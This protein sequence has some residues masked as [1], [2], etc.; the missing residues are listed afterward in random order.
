[1][2]AMKALW[3]RVVVEKVQLVAGWASIVLLIFAWL[4]WVFSMPSV[5]LA[6]SIG[7]AY[8]DF[9]MGIALMGYYI[10]MGILAA[11]SIIPFGGIAVW[12][13]TIFLFND[14]ALSCFGL[15]MTDWPVAVFF[16]IPMA[17]GMVGQ[18]IMDVL[19]VKG[20]LGFRSAFTQTPGLGF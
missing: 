14:A 1:M 15:S 20:I 19:L 9:L 12:F 17:L 8:S 2:L 3:D 7:T 10:W 4:L 11:L 18:I 16:W 6:F 13:L 5:I